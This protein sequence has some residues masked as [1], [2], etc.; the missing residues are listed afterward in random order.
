MAHLSEYRAI[1][2]LALLLPSEVYVHLTLPDP[3]PDIITKRIKEAVRQLN[4][5]EKK[6]ML[7]RAKEI[8]AYT[9]AIIE[10]LG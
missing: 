4:T 7:A 3:P 2:P 10:T 9:K 5:D 8:Q 6:S 1:D